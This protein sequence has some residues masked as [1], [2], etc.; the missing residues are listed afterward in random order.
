M[1]PIGGSSRE[2]W[3]ARCILGK[4]LNSGF[5]T[6]QRSRSGQCYADTCR[7][8]LGEQPV[9]T[10]PFP[11]PPSCLEH[12]VMRGLLLKALFSR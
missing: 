12:G 6:I 10:G 9:D 2:M 7:R 1:G 3:D 8:D 4:G 5:E 11:P